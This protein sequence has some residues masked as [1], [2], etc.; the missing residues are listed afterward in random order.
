HVPGVAREEDAV[1]L[2]P[3]VDRDAR[4]LAGLAYHLA[5]HLREAEARL[6]PVVPDA[7][8]VGRRAVLPGHRPPGLA[9]GRRGASAGAALHPPVALVVL[10]RRELLPADPG[11]LVAVVVPVVVRV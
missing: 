3:A 11:V 8:G 2:E 6:H 10:P 4:R 7:V 1:L 5:P 9:V